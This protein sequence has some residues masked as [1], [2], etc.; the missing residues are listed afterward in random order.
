MIPTILFFFLRNYR[1]RN[2]Q[3]A[4]RLEKFLF[5]GGKIIAFVVFFLAITQL[6]LAQSR[7]LDYVIKRKGNEVGTLSILQQSSGNRTIYKMKSEVKTRMIL[8]FTAKGQEEAV[9]ENGVLV[10]SWVY[11]KM[12]G[13]EKSNKR[14]QLSGSSY[15][16]SKGSKTE[17]LPVPAI[18]YNMLRLYTQEPVN[19]STVYSDNF[20]E[21][22]D[23]KRMGHQHYRIRFPDDNY[24]DYF[25]RNGI[26]VKVEVHHSLYNASI[27]LK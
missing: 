14:L 19:I 8:M 12:N 23:I 11:R 26:C 22:V 21:Y 10:S 27:E 6:A 5:K 24:S 17:P 7:Q 16:V 25:Y 18:K 2:P 15:V 20:Q 1:R 3:G 9:Y 4:Q 13:N